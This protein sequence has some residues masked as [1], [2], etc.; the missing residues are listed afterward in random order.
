MIIVERHP[1]PHFHAPAPATSPLKSLLIF[2]HPLPQRVQIIFCFHL[3]PKVF[4]LS[5]LFSRLVGNADYFQVV[6]N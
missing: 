6:Y 3:F 4:R 5:F 2:H 1:P